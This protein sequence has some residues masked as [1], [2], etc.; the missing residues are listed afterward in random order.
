MTIENEAVLVSLVAELHDEVTSLRDITALG[1]NTLPKLEQVL[2]KLNH[3]VVLWPKVFDQRKEMLGIIGYVGWLFDAKSSIQSTF[4][5]LEEF[6]SCFYYFREFLQ[7]TYDSASQASQSAIEV[8]LRE[9][10]QC[11]I[12]NENLNALRLSAKTYLETALEYHEISYDHIDTLQGIV[13]QNLEVC[14]S[15]QQEKLTSPVRHPPRYT[16]EQIIKLLAKNSEVGE[17]NIPNFST[18][19]SVLS[20]KFMKLRQQ[21]PPI[22]KSL[23]EVVP[24]RI[25]H[26]R[27]R[28]NCD[29]HEIQTLVDRLQKKSLS[30][31]SDFKFLQEEI[32]D[33]SVELVDN[34]WNALF[35]NLNQEI[36]NLIENVLRIQQK[37]GNANLPRIV[38]EEYTKMLEKNAK[39]ITK[40][41]NI[42]YH[43]MEFL[44]LN[45][46]I[47]TET[48]RQSK[49]WLEIRPKI[50]RVLE[51]VQPSTNI[52][53]MDLESTKENKGSMENV[54]VG[55]KTLKLDG[56]PAQR[57]L[58]PHP[59]NIIGDSLLRKMRIRPASKESPTLSITAF[60]NKMQVKSEIMQD[61]GQKLIFSET[62]DLVDYEA[63]SPS[64]TTSFDHQKAETVTK[65]LDHRRAAIDQISK[66]RADFY[67]NQKSQI[68]R[69]YVSTRSVSDPIPS[70]YRTPLMNRGISHDITLTTPSV[71][72]SY[73]RSALRRP[74]P[75]SE[76]LMTPRST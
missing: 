47:A 9:S 21:I 58:Q 4:S 27:Q 46:K 10:D 32:R 70:V 28:S 33:L 38:R 35:I 36:S 60:P 14:L 2:K 57:V 26:F 41:F 51:K 37:L 54:T 1:N 11:I 15:L 67:R 49:R 12:M 43:G 62:P 45:A 75:I 64:V 22:E 72:F 55:L 6:A 42:I 30:L 73:G 16:L 29:S 48:N 76:L 50:D 53:D 69:P 66:I 71:K 23:V 13:N 24:Q 19:E 56:R 39:T 52:T 44:L 25:E 7:T 31:N 40:T 59:N 3:L 68:P 74:T 8:Y 65:N 20:K 5:D 34:R 61:S 18:V 63:D 17:P